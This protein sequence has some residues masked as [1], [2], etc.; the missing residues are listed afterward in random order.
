MKIVV[1]V[2]DIRDPLE[3]TV[4]FLR[5]LSLIVGSLDVYFLIPKIAQKKIYE[6]DIPFKHQFIMMQGYLNSESILVDESLYDNC[7]V[8]HKVLEK[9]GVTANFLQLATLSAEY[10]RIYTEFIDLIKPDL[11]ICWNGQIHLDQTCFRD[12]VKDKQIP[13]FFLERGLVPGSVF[14]DWEGVNVT[15]SPYKWTT[16]EI[17]TE[18]FSSYYPDILEYVTNTGIAIVALS[19]KSVKFKKPYI[20]FPLQRD[21]DSNLVINSP[22]F[23]NMYSI[24]RELNNSNLGIEIH[25][26][27]HPEDP[28][29]HYTKH[30]KFSNPMLIDKSEFDLEKHVDSCQAVMTVNSTIGFSALLKNKKVITLG[31][32]IYSQKG[33]TIDYKNFDSLSSAIEYSLQKQITQEEM[34]LKTAFISKLIMTHHLIFQDIKLAYDQISGLK[35]MVTKLLEVAK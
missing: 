15:S 11:C 30:L 4:R 14:Y 32:S 26:R 5:K 18:N 2:Q 10:K 6:I 33:F 3:Y 21:S 12:L 31:N 24:L 9:L 17:L 27:H 35:S 28:K 29:G 23:K 16:Q 22:Y 13:T 20:L 8:Q 7:R 19:Q 25:Y 1:Q 34:M